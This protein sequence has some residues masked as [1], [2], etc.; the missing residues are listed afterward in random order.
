[1][2]SIICTLLFLLYSCNIYGLE[3]ITIDRGR[4]DPTPI[5]INHFDS[6][7]TAD[8]AIGRRITD[9]IVTNLK[10]S[11]LFKSIPP[12]SFIEKKI[13]IDHAPLFVAWRQISAN[14]LLNGEVKKLSSGKLKI[15]FILWDTILEKKLVGEVLELSTNVW[16]RAAHKIADKIYEKITGDQGYFDSKIVYVSEHGPYLKKIKRIAIM[17]QDGANHKYLTD[18]KNLVLMPKLSPKNDKILYVSYIQKK[19]K[20]FI[21]NLSNGKESL[22]GTFSNMSF[23]SCFSQDGTKVLMAIEKNGATNIFEVDLKNMHQTQLT[24]NQYINVSPSYSPDSSHIVFNSDRSGS[25]ELYIMDRDGGNVQRISFGGGI[26]A[27][28]SWSP[29]G[30]YIAFTKIS[31]EEGF[32]IGVMRA[33][34]DVTGDHSERIIASG[35]LVEGPCWAPNG[36]IIM[37]TKAYAPKYNMTKRNRIYSID[38]TGYNEQEIQTPQDASGPDWSRTL[39]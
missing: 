37:F 16:R 18:G 13:G 39:D 35:Y 12:T 38:L 20:V 29:R 34:A 30:D 6:D 25:R 28:P 31:R 23:S 15:S 8:N 14:L 3:T 2:R 33:N 9:V 27:A 24:N 17:D 32:T 36:R 22:V 26:Y 19:P 4:T 21:K 1:M 7:N 10:K 5:A 11:G